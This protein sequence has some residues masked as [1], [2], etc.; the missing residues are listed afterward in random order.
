MTPQK[1]TRELLEQ[2]NDVANV[3]PKESFA[4]AMLAVDFFMS[5]E[6]IYD[7]T[8]WFEVLDELESM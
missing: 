3:T 2:I 5:Y 7:D 4:I 8:F 1:M 6:G